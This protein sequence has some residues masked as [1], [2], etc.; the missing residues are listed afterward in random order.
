MA[1]FQPQ[2]N[3]EADR[4]TRFKDY[5]QEHYPKSS[6][7]HEQKDFVHR[8]LLNGPNKTCPDENKLWINLFAD[9][10]IHFVGE[11]QW[12]LRQDDQTT[13]MQ[14]IDFLNVAMGKAILAMFNSQYSLRQHIPHDRRSPEQQRMLEIHPNILNVPI[15][16]ALDLGR[17]LHLRQKHVASTAPNQ[18]ALIEDQHLFHQL[19]EQ[20]Q[21]MGVMGKQPSSGGPSGS[22]QE[23]M[24]QGESGGEQVEWTPHG[25]EDTFMRLC[26][27]KVWC[28]KYEQEEEWSVSKMSNEWLKEGI[29]LYN[30]VSYHWPQCKIK[31]YPMSQ[32]AH[33]RHTAMN[34]WIPD[35]VNRA[36]SS[37][38]GTKPS[39]PWITDWTTYPVSEKRHEWESYFCSVMLRSKNL[40]KL[41]GKREAHVMD[42]EGDMKGSGSGERSGKMQKTAGEAG[43]GAK[44]GGPQFDASSMEYRIQQIV[45]HEISDLEKRLRNVERNVTS[46]HHDILKEMSAHFNPVR[47]QLHQLNNGQGYLANMLDKIVK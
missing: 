26:C 34:S 9:H 7:T 13:V 23:T 20:I 1:N 25:A 14:K 5:V 33:I 31:K 16:F 3:I 39:S 27:Y 6:F 2:F 47:N 28:E 38:S 37:Y 8:A 18:Q 19:H 24:S 15:D 40:A 4:W 36:V 22:S 32:F 42:V 30:H 45:R 43:V 17:I 44:A 12:P 46:S 29:Q 41:L 35:V 11:G 10:L 21:Q